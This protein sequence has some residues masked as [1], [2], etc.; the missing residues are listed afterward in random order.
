MGATRP[1]RLSEEQI[2]DH[3]SDCP[4]WAVDAGK[5]QRSFRFGDFSE[6]FGFMVRSALV[7]ES[8]NHHPEWQN[9]WNRVDVQLTT[10]D[11]GGLTRLDFELAEAM[12]RL[13]S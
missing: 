13:A 7:A 10:H 3:L 11:A 6:A 4:G 9:V 5:L 8:L 2:R 1:E 12:S